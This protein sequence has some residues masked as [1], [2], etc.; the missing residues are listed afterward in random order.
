M[1]ETGQIQVYSS[2]KLFSNFQVRR[3][4]AVGK[5]IYE[6]VGSEVSEEIRKKN[7]ECKV[8]LNGIEIEPGVWHCVRPKE[9]TVVDIN[10]IPQG[11]NGGKNPLAIVLTIALLIAAPYAGGAIAASMVGYAG[12]TFATVVGGL[13]QAMTIAVGIVGALA[14]NAIAPPPKQNNRQLSNNPAESPTQ[15]I[16]GASN[17]LTPYGVVP[18]CLG[19]NRMFPLLAANNYTETVGENQYVRQLFTY[20]WGEN[21]TLEEL[22]IGETNIS[23]FTNIDVIHKLNGNLH[24]PTE[25][26]SNDVV[27][28]NYNIL[29]NEVDGYTVRTTSLNVD[30]VILD[31]TFPRGLVTFDSSGNKI[32]T[33]VLLDV[34]YSVSGA[35]SW[36]P[37]VSS[38]KSISQSDVNIT[39]SSILKTL[40]VYNEGYRK[41]VV[42]IDKFT[43]Q[44]SIILGTQIVESSLIAEGLQVPNI[45]EYKIRLSTIIVRTRR[46][47][48]SGVITK[49]VISFTDDRDL[50]LIGTIIQSS[51]DFLVSVP[52][53]TTSVRIAS[54]GLSSSGIYAIDARGEAIRK[55]HRIVFPS[56]G[57]YDVRI[58]RISLDTDSDKIYDKVYLT[59]VKSFKYQTPVRL[60]G[61]N[62]TALRIKA[63]DQLNGSIDQFNAVVSSVVLDYNSDN[64]DWIPAITSNPASLYRYVLQ[65][66]ANARALPDSKIDLETLQEW[67]TYCVEKNYTYNRVIDYRA[68]VDEILRDIAS[69]GSASP[70]LI[71]GKRSVVIDKIKEDI[72]QMVTPRNSWGYKGVM[73]YPTLPHALRMTFRNEDKGFIQDEII[74]YNTGYDENNATLFETINLPS[75]TNSD[76]AYKTGVRH[77]RAAILR[78]EV[79]SWMMDFEN[80]SF[81]RGARIKFISDTIKVGIGQARIK[82]IIL[83]NDDTLVTGITFDDTITIPNAG[84]YFARYRLSDGNQ[85]HQEIIT[86]VGS[87][88]TFNFVT[89]FTIDNSPEIGDLIYFCEVGKEL[90]LIVTKIEPAADLTAKI[91]AFNYAPEIFEAEEGYIPIFESNIT[92]PIQFIRLTEPLLLSLQSDETVMLKNSDGSLISR[93][94]IN[95]QNVNEDNILTYVKIR[96][97][98]STEFK[99]ANILESSP[100][101]VIIT[102]LE[103]NIYYDI[104]IRYKRSNGGFFSPVLEINNY[105]FIGNGN[106]PQNVTNFTINVS[107][108]TALFKWDKCPDIDFSHSIMKFTRTFSGATYETAQ[109]V[110]SEIYEN[111]LS[112]PFIP[113]T[114]FI[115]HVDISG[116]ES[117]DSASIITYDP[118]ILANQIEVLQEDT[119]FSGLKNNVVINGGNSIILDN[120]GQLTGVYYFDNYLDLGDIYTSIVSS[121]IIANGAYISGSGVN[122]IF[123]MTNLFIETDLYGVVADSWKLKLKYRTSNLNIDPASTWEDSIGSLNMTAVNSAL[124]TT[125]GFFA[126]GSNKYWTSAISSSSFL[127]DPNLASTPNVLCI[128]AEFKNSPTTP[129][130]TKYIFNTG[131]F[132]SSV[133]GVLIARRTNSNILVRVYSSTQIASVEFTS[134]DSQEYKLSIIKTSTHL[135]VYDKDTQVLL[136]SVAVSSSATSTTP[137][138]VRIGQRANASLSAENYDNDIYKILVWDSLKTLDEIAA[139]DNIGLAHK[140]DFTQFDLTNWQDFYAGQIQ[141]R[142][143]EFMLEMESFVQNIT[144][145]VTKLSVTIDMP[146]RI[147]RGENLSCNASIGSTVTY[148]TPFKNSP[149][150]TITLQNAST[151]DRIDYLTKDSSGFSFKVYNATAAAYVDRDYDYIA[152]GYGRIN[153]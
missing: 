31:V 35:G 49:E 98:G 63:T 150:V 59:S 124:L 16:E 141:F 73:M 74:V 133:N 66:N 50:T 115:K 114:Y 69:A 44:T 134:V 95:L 153:I 19:R 2:P 8:T 146:D 32:Q 99:N 71:D 90:D 130:S 105:K 129:S 65:C 12:I 116:N 94:I 48:I 21:L 125:K 9:G 61:I 143:I 53:P 100:E 81:T 149:A 122:N 62:G 6:I 47:K 38:Y 17:R 131:A 13:A 24:E 52:S 140:W 138:T 15:F 54:G 102:G 148:S 89:P 33:T 26:Y 152:S 86:S 106:P 58:K 11:G 36:S 101:R 137:N 68:T 139:L 40:G 135:Y 75:C 85:H 7:I 91:T 77:F 151:D 4:V 67:H 18:I 88:K 5:T 119:S 107:G 136:G 87:F 144:P 29:L 23:E 82:S 10:V 25:I 30:E 121:E 43:G 22:K 123:T 39:A 128:L 127:C 110:E 80:L 60:A 37:S 79:H 28:D 112:L 113:G 118:G 51:G 97:T 1:T 117:N 93:L 96:R 147:E 132:L 120:T 42:V 45:P 27:Q 70:T 56:Q 57:T 46:H 14:I 76:L 78:P 20:G 64:N 84:F 34:Q 92:T 103:D 3:V 72:P 126:D 83:N 142:S 41:D 55:S 109:I 145:Q 108:E 111:R 104:Q